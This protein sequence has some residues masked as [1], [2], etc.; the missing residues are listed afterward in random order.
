MARLHQTAMERMLER[1]AEGEL[2]PGAWLPS[3]DRLR[4]E[5]QISRGV[6]RETVQA[7]KERGVVD[8]K[9][10]RG[11]WVRP[12]EEWNVLDP[13][14]LAAIIGARRFDLLHE[15]VDCRALLAP[16][17]VAIAAERATGEA[18]VHLDETHARLRDA[19][20]RRRRPNRD[21]DPFVVAEIEF[22]HTVSRLAGN[23][24]LARLLDPVDQGLAIVHHALTADERPALVRQL[25]RVRKAIAARDPEAARTALAGGVRQTRLW[26][27]QEQSPAG[28][29]QPAP[30]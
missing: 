30:A 27:K 23:R 17:V 9:H 11:Q 2:A 29:A 14:V 10:G 1:I 6:A 20:G 22:N 7:L 5:L 8:V 15:L 16:P 12:E 3:E 24:I 28:R 18:I 13:Q 26:L 19:A 4:N 25:G 21:D